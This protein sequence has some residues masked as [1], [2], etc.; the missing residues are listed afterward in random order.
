MDARAGDSAHDLAQRYAGSLYFAHQTGIEKA[1]CGLRDSGV[2]SFRYI[3]SDN[4]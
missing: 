3:K 4:Q 1:Y 2:G